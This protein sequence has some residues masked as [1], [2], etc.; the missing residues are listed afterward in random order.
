M[1]VLI[2]E[3]KS[4]NLVSRLPVV[5]GGLNYEPTEDEYFTI[6]WQCAVDDKIV[7]QNCRDVYLLKLIHA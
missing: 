5:L 6:A 7:D 1:D 2:I 3:L 4:G